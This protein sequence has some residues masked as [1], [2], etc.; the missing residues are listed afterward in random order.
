MAV[1]A[2][3]IAMLLLSP[4]NGKVLQGFT[5]K[6]KCA[7]CVAVLNKKGKKELHWCP[8]AETHAKPGAPVCV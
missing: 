2:A 4:A 3:I 5:H 7:S 8:L 6:I 1:D